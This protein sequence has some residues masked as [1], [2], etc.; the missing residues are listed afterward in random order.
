MAVVGLRNL[1][2]AKLTKDDGT[3]VTYEVPIKLAKAINVS[4]T[5]NSTSATLYADDGPAE[6]ATAL[7]Q[8]DVSIGI[9][10]LST[11]NQ[12]LLL[13]HA[14]NT[15]G[16]LEKRAG[17]VAP[18]VALGFSSPTSDGGEKYTWLFKGK[19]MLSEETAATRGENLEF[20]TPT[21]TAAFVKRENDDQWQASVN[22]NDTGVAAGVVD[23]WFT[24]VYKKTV[25]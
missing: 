10:D 19:F 12:A 21:L 14:V 16:V 22:S 5:P 3:G 1:H 8:I 9:D 2:I 7:G 17:D 20:Q 11:A 6:I 18:Y 23:G 13:G 4:I 24:N 25:V 15:E